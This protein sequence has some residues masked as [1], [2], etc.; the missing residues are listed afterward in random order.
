MILSCQTLP[1]DSNFKL[2]GTTYFIEVSETVYNY[3]NANLATNKITFSNTLLG[4]FVVQ[5]SDF[6][7]TSISNVEKKK[8]SAL[9]QITDYLQFK[10]NMLFQLAFLQLMT[11]SA[12]LRNKGHFINELN[13]AA[14]TTE[15][16]ASND[17]ALIDTFNKY[18][19]AWNF[20][21]P[22]LTRFNSIISTISVIESATTELEIT[23][24]INSLFPISLE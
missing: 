11:L 5:I 20:M 8:L 15:I 4:D 17:S 13:V 2:L 1:N 3:V 19:A 24:A 22:Y 12:V 7:L 21:Q 18:L 9:K 10:N 16:N 6:T 14:K 23:N